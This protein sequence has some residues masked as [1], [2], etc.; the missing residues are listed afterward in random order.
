MKGRNAI[1]YTI[2]GLTALLIFC[3]SDYIQWYGDCYIYRFSFATGEPIGSLADIIRSQYR[4]YFIMNG[5]IW[6]H[7]L[8]QGYEALWGQTAFAVSN[9]AVYMAFVIL[10]ARVC[11]RSWRRVSDVLLCVLA[12][13]FFCDISYNPNCQIGYV[14]SATATMG[15]ILM[16][17]RSRDDRRPGVW[18]L[19]LLL[20]LSV[21]AG[22]GNEAIAIGTGAALIV[23]F[24]RNFRRLT[25]AQWVMAAG[26]GIGGLLVCL[27]PGILVR[28][29]SGGADIVWSA[30][31]LLVYSRMLY[32]LVITLAVL[33]LRRKLRLREFAADNMFFIVALVAL[34]AFNF[35]IGIGLSSR[36][37]FGVELFS[38]I[39]TVRAL[40]GVAVPRWVMAV[41]AVV[42]A[43]L[44]C[45]KFEY[46]RLSNDDL[47]RLRREIK[48][49][50]DMT[51]Y[52]DFHRYPTIVHPT[53]M[54]NTYKVYFFAAGAIYDDIHD[55][56]NIYR[57]RNDDGPRPPYIATDG[58]PLMKIYPT[59]MK[60]VA[61][62]ADRNFAMRCSDGMYLVVRDTAA[63]ARFA[64]NRDFNIL[65][66][67][68][69]KEPFEVVFD[70]KDRLNSDGMEVMY[71]DFSS[72]L[73]ENG[74]ITEF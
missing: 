5:R 40:A 45:L 58:M 11:G 36:Q 65:G 16:Y 39:L 31:R 34:L 13:L 69:P 33:R 48:E 4:H 6:V 25:V 46:L 74:T 53:E 50:D 32:V 29:S 54:E 9:A 68:R 27:S 24:A 52:I 42:V 18:R 60:D 35:F 8:C 51:V 20:L 43:A 62:R 61:G 59:V 72:P 15:F 19:T 63:P 49:M 7:A 10:F 30:F 17:F 44:Y 28:A 67:K 57:Y 56:G 1:S 26:F 70:N 21:L 66:L 12:I 47:A 38:A 37:L 55:G 23:D 22:N 41:A 71:S 64:I 3:L 2:L 14:W 73:V